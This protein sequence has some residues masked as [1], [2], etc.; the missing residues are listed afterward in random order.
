MPVI[1]TFLLHVLTTPTLMIDPPSLTHTNDPHPHPSHTNDPTP[2][3]TTLMTPYPPPPTEVL[4]R[5]ALEKYDIMWMKN[6]DIRKLKKEISTQLWNIV[7]KSIITEIPEKKK[8]KAIILYIAIVWSE[9]RDFDHADLI[10]SYDRTLFIFIF[11]N[12]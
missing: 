12:G 11:E 6:G 1:L 10:M 4:H 7:G 3:P 9:S 5:L 8:C 2:P